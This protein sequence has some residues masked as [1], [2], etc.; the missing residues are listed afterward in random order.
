[1]DSGEREQFR[2]ADSLIGFPF[3]HLPE[4]DGGQGRECFD[5]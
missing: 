3:L 4:R 1:M 5:C 2:R